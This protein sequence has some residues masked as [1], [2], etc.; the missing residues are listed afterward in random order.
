[1]PHV[2]EK[3]IFQSEFVTIRGT[4]GE[5]GAV[6]SVFIDANRPRTG[7]KLRVADLKETFRATLLRA[8]EDLSVP[9]D[10]VVAVD[11][12]LEADPDDSA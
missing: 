8:L 10:G 4:R 11:A 2:R 12:W 7:T 9:P 1:M 3:V 5:D 6:E